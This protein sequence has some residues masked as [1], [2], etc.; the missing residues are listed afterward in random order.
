MRFYQPFLIFSCCQYIRLGFLRKEEYL[1][2]LH[3]SNWMDFSGFLIYVQGGARGGQ[4]GNNTFQ[5][6]L[7]SYIF[8]I[9]TIH[10]RMICG[11]R[12]R[13]FIEV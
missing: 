5:I 9:F 10:V 13:I 6:Q 2:P 4:G 12:N 1:K 7:I 11:G 8:Y 3:L